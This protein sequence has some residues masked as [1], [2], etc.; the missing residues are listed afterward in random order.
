[1]NKLEYKDK[2]VRPV[3]KLE[4]RTSGSGQEKVNNA[5]CS[6]YLKTCSLA[7]NN[8]SIRTLTLPYRS[9]KTLL[10]KAVGRLTQRTNQTKTQ[11]QVR[12]PSGNRNNIPLHTFRPTASEVPTA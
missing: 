2:T 12:T 7:R 11:E 10:A 5:L 3:I 9:F 4:P 6:H 8:G 1:M